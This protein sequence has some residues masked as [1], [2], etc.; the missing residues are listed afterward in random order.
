[1]IHEPIMMYL[2]FCRWKL[3]LTIM[4]M[5]ARTPSL[6]FTIL[7]YIMESLWERNVRHHVSRRSQGGFAGINVLH[8]SVSAATNCLS[9]LP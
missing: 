4:M 7:L 9:S 5:N 6:Y 3:L 8:K 1:M 2:G